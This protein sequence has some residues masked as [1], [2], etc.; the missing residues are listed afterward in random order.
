MA[1]AVSQHNQVKRIG[2][3]L[4]NKNRIFTAAFVAMAVSAA[5]AISCV[6]TAEAQSFSLSMPEEYLDYTV[7][8]ENGTLWAKI[9]GMY[10]MHLAGANG[11]FN[12]PMYY[13]TPPN[14]TNM[15]VHLDDVELP[16]SNGNDATP[17]GRHYTDIGEWEMI[18]TII[19]PTSEDFVLRIHYEHPVELI[20]GTY[21]F[22]YDLNIKD[23]LSPTSPKSTAHFR[24]SIEA[25]VSGVNVYTTGTAGFRSS[26]S[27]V[28]Y[29]STEVD[30][31]KV[32]EFDI[33]SEYN[34]QLWGD[35]AVLLVDVQIPE[36]PQWILLLML[37]AGSMAVIFC[38]S[39]VKKDLKLSLWNK[40]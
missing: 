5:W 12:L 11:S 10:P 2:E 18:Y 8:V 28:A 14:T 34:K 7:A 9:D 3:N 16:W 4:M 26:W 21:T 15:H 33:V 35:I 32:V 40:Y 17:G 25:N 19:A 31:V 27:P 24:I 22:L 30:G 6:G 23:Y 36:L 38:R 29:D 13:P 20:N 39:N 1:E 37:A